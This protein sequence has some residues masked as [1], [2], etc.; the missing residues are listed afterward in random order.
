MLI[1]E[2]D[3]VVA[4]HEQTPRPPRAIKQASVESALIGTPIEGLFEEA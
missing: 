2:G 1:V 3:S 4:E